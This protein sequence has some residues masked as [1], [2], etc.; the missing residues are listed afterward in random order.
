M[1]VYNWDSYEL[2]PE[3][4]KPSSNG[5]S[6]DDPSYSLTG[7][8]S[9]PS[10]YDFQPE[11][12]HLGGAPNAAPPGPQPYIYTDSNSAPPSQ[13][14]DQS[15]WYG[16]TPSVY[17]GESRHLGPTTPYES[18]VVS[19][20]DKPRIGSSD[21]SSSSSR[22]STSQS[23]IQN[24]APAPTVPTLSPYEMPERGT[25]PVFNAPEWDKSEIS[26]MTQ[27]QAAAPI[28]TLREMHQRMA[29]RLPSNP[30]SRVLLKD[31]L[32][33]YGSGLESAI[34]GAKR[35]ALSEYGQKYGREFQ[36]ENTKYTGAQREFEAD[37][38]ARLEDAKQ[39]N[40]IENQNKTN[41][42]QADYAEYMKY[43]SVSE[44]SVVDQM[45]DASRQR[46][47]DYV[48]SKY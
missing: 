11:E 14:T 39:R 36:A 21:S 29:S 23:Y 33:G 41:Q 38:T 6:F 44:P 12:F 18:S 15:S 5:F 16:Y 46:Y 2:T 19:Y 42:Y 48:S 35:G 22:S 31:A 20:W 25:A 1:A 4:N 37:Y 8:G 43:G 17:S 32:A 13:P 9:E 3:A 47:D 10:F 40:A 7:G 27:E 30:Q 34:A 45:R 26:R 28:R 24:R